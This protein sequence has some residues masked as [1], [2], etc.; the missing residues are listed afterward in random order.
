MLILT[1][2]VIL[3]AGHEQLG[4]TQKTVTRAGD[5]NLGG[6]F[7]VH[8]KDL[9]TGRCGD[10]SPLGLGHA[11][12]M[13][14][15]IDKINKDP[16]LLPNTTLGYQ[17]HDYCESSL[18]AMSYTY[19][20]VKRTDPQFDCGQK[21]P[22][23]GK[24]PAPIAALIGPPDSGSSVLVGSLLGISGIP[25]ISFAATSEELSDPRY[26]H[27]FR[28]VP[29]DRQQAK[30]IADL[31]EHF[32]WSYVA[33]VA[34]DDSYGR[35]G[36]WTVEKESYA[37]NTFC[38][39]LSEYIPRLDYMSKLRI[40]V[41]KLK[42]H[43]NVKVVVLWLFGGYGRAFLR[44]VARQ[45][46]V[47]RTWILSDALAAEEPAVLEPFFPLLHGALGVQPRYVRDEAFEA[48]L[49]GLPG[50][51][52]LQ[53]PWWD[54]FWE[55][56]FNCSLHHCH[57][58]ESLPETAI[59]KLYDTYLPYVI[60]AVNAT[61]HALHA[62]LGSGPAVFSQQWPGDGNIGHPSPLE[63]S[64]KNITFEGL[65]GTVRFDEF[66]NPSTSSYDI[67]NFQ[68]GGI[69]ES[70]ERKGEPVY[71]KK[72]VGTWD[73]MR[74]NK[75]SVED[76][77]I[78]W[79]GATNWTVPKSDCGLPCRAGYVQRATTPCCW[80]C[81]A[82]PVGTFSLPGASNCTQCPKEKTS[83]QQRS[84]CVDLAV[85]NPHWKSSTGLVIITF[86]CLGQLLTCLT[87]CTFI[88]YRD[89]PIV[90]GCHR[91]LTF[92]LLFA[93][94]C[95][96][97]L[98]LLSLAPATDVTCPVTITWRTLCVTW[99]V[100]LLL[101]KTIHILRV[102]NT[103]T[104]ADRLRHKG[105]TTEVK[106]VL[107]VLLDLGLVSLV[108]LWMLLDPPS[109]QIIIQ[110]RESIILVCRPYR[111]TTG[112]ALHAA[113]AIGVA[114]LSLFTTFYAFKARRL[115]ENFNEGRYIVFAMYI[116]LVAAITYY[117]A[118]FGV[119]GWN[120]T[121]VN[122]V[123]TLVS[124]YGLLGSIYVPKL[125]VIFCCPE[126]NTRG[127][128]RSQVSRYT[129]RQAR[130]PVSTLEQQAKSNSEG[131]NPH[132]WGLPCGLRPGSH[133]LPEHEYRWALRVTPCFFFQGPT[134]EFR[135]GVRTRVQGRDLVLRH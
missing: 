112:L 102:F 15:A 104:R 22:S 131:P 132:C 110:A 99:C 78:Q 2:T 67:I 57:G 129:F 62:M 26:K 75:L 44:E 8:Y 123:A 49:E 38:V 65:T 4:A 100:S 91:E 71:L 101:I 47:D 107:V 48:F 92:L 114:F 68:L 98:A 111:G 89:T 82:C 50:N 20:V 73:G 27:F 11:L 124:T 74:T 63:Q 93:I 56:E 76:D 40:T 10:F 87:I 106:A 35:Y 70:S 43:S 85:R 120:S 88:K 1:Q 66:G 115:P 103:N 135:H 60:D 64:L 30:A 34:V 69:E 28:T 36:V 16:S 72:L 29:P 108:C 6:L 21:D 52:D 79:K 80:K 23:G 7:F 118:E 83:N 24:A 94:F 97:G 128:A 55:V 18:L 17:I 96:F 125:Y 58:N 3:S 90:K 9:S 25:S 130:A 39:A 86:T 117:P 51:A 54:E 122:C 12:A 61:A 53:L 45:G 32:G 113:N 84:S 19:E 116:I 5:I 13:L 59:R 31:I 95:Y 134:P 105:C 121:I 42:I 33:T 109:Q 81:V 126:Q 37:R 127:A 77:S 46:V 41:S 133:L 119:D 14:Y